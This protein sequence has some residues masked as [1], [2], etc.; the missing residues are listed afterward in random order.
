MIYGVASFQCVA[1]G[2]NISISW[3]KDDTKLPRMSTVT[4]SRNEHNVT[5]VLRIVNTIGYYAGNYCCIAENE[6]GKVS[7]CAELT[8]KGNFILW[9][10]GGTQPPW[11]HAKLSVLVRCPD[12]RSLNIC[13][14]LDTM[15]VSHAAKKMK[16]TCCK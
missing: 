1:D 9:L 12:F 10:Y 11:D 6:G 15:V 13:M 4:E 16:S 8:V 5:S 3:Q 7:S 2:Y 14:L